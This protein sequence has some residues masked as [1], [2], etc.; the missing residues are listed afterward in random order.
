MKNSDCNPRKTEHSKTHSSS[1]PML[2]KQPV[3]K[4]EQVIQCKTRLQAGRDS[5]PPASTLERGLCSLAV[6][7]PAP[8]LPPPVTLGDAGQVGKGVTRA[9]QEQD[10]RILAS[11]DWLG[12]TTLRTRAFLPGVGAPA[13]TASC[14]AKFGKARNHLAAWTV[15]QQWRAHKK[16]RETRGRRSPGGDGCLNCSA[17]AL[18]AVCGTK[19]CLITASG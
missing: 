5:V 7:L 6:S 16:A 4:S 10:G 15:N 13:N 2:Q 8:R 9:L 12:E 19:A 14:T 11:K 3:I 1:H 17:T 18:Q